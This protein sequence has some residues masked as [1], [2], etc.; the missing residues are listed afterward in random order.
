MA[1]TYFF[2]R[3]AE[4]AAKAFLERHKISVLVVG[5]PGL[6]KADF[7]QPICSMSHGEALIRNLL[8]QRD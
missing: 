3:V 6:T 5:G 7:L 1:V 2:H 8:L 4:H